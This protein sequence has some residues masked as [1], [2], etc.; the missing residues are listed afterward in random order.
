MR[1]FESANW[2]WSSEAAP[3][4][5][6]VDFLEEFTTPCARG[7]LRI[8]ADAQYVAFLNGRF[9]G[10]GQ[11]PDYPAYKV[12][13]EYDVSGLIVPGLNRLE[14]TGYCPV[15]ESMVYKL[16]VPGVIYEIVTEEM[17]LVR[18]GKNT[19]CAPNG[20]YRSG[21]V[22]LNTTQ[23]GYTF[24]YDENAARGA[25]KAAAQVEGTRKF[26][27]RPV[28]RQEIG[29]LRT[30][31]LRAQG[32]Y[33]E[34]PQARAIGERMQYASM[35]YRELE[36]LTG[37]KAFPSFPN[38]AGVRF[39]AETGDGLFVVL[40][41]LREESGWLDLEIETDEPCE[42]LVGWGEHLDD[43]RV[44]AWV[45]GRNFVAS[46]RTAPGRRRFV[47]RFRHIGLRYLQLFVPCRAFTLYYAGVLPADYP[48]ERAGRFLVSDRLHEKIHE[49]SLRTLVLCMH[50][51]YEDCPWR[52]QGLYTMDSR[53]QMLAGYY[54]FGEYDMPRAS[55][56]LM[57]LSVREDNRLLE[58]CAPCHFNY[59][60]VS[61][62]IGYLILLEEYLLFS[63]DYD[64]AREMLPA[65]RGLADTVLGFIGE[66]GLM[67]ALKGD[68]YMNFYEW[69]PGMD[70]TGTFEEDDE[71]VRYDAP[72][73]FLTMLALRRFA[74]MLGYLGDAN[75]SGYARSADRLARRAHEAFW[76]EEQGCYCTYANST[77]KWH[78]A[79]LTQAWAVCADACPDAR[80]VDRALESLASGSLQATM[81]SYSQYKFEALLR[82]P[83]KYGTWVFDRIAKDWGEMLFSGATSFWETAQGGW[84]FERAG[85]LCHGWSGLPVYFYYAY[86]LGIR[87][88][89]PGFRA[90]VVDPVPSGLYGLEG[91]VRLR[92]GRQIL[93]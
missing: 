10:A 70:G 19:R 82:R 9:V 23:M 76:I 38:E 64:F 77:R 66:N 52:E 36:H 50:A 55:L 1:A 73:N 18:S 51:H 87:P 12:Y 84:D 63:G 56:R 89:L 74:R 22:D 31:L 29:E 8:S 26:F 17:V 13:D 16:G 15:R 33:G 67:A 85:S 28:K 25:L 21:P 88:T 40:D 39:S 90:Y 53:N 20:R 75:A 32:V 68:T 46:Y 5:A 47:H 62:S 91:A 54:A 58:V 6:Y 79:E 65:A 57:S 78:F 81:L 42:V 71:P 24:L 83:E 14:V 61:F 41:L 2:V 60:L 92:D 48:V 27:P 86:A 59:S 3:V 7:L 45:G 4:N 49:T 44:R 30:S 11:Y 80:V 34:Y 72:L 93:L 43:L 37:L 69:T 35:A